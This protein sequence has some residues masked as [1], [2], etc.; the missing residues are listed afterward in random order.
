MVD[1]ATTPRML[2][3]E[4]WAALD[5]DVPGELVDGVLEEEEVASWA[6]EL[7]VSWLIR[8]LGGWIVPRGGFVLGSETA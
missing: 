3:L 6:H 1:P 5:E 4:E 2:T 8:L 7:V